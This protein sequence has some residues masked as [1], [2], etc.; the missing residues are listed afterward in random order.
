MTKKAVNQNAKYVQEL[1]DIIE[2]NF[3]FN[4]KPINRL[5][6]IDKSNNSINQNKAEKLKELKKKN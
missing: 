2:P 6:L 4:Y 3:N 1:I 5:Q